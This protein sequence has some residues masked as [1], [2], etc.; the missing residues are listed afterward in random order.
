M[1]ILTAGPERLWVTRM[2]KSPKELNVPKY[3]HTDIFG[4]EDSSDEDEEENTWESVK[5]VKK[6]KLQRV[7]VMEQEKIDMALHSHKNPMLSQNELTEW[8]QH[9]FVI[10]RTSF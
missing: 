5:D 7:R 4:D 10:K 3:K 9:I 2:E 6:R 8:N 1:K